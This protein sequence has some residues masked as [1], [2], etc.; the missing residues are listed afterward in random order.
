[1]LKK[2]RM[3]TVGI[4][5]LCILAVIAIIGGIWFALTH[6][7]TGYAAFGLVAAVLLVIVILILKLW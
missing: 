4:V 6:S 7:E 2:L 5:I 1:M 3:G